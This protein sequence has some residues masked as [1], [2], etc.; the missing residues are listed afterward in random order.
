MLDLD[1][2]TAFSSQGL[3]IALADSAGPSTNYAPNS[4][5][6]KWHYNLDSVTGGLQSNQTLIPE[7]IMPHTI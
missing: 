1:F 6:L 7:F 4:G 3:T 5:P 2:D